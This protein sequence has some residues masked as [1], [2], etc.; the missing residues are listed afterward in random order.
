MGWR[1]QPVIRVA[2]IGDEI[3]VCVS[4][5]EIYLDDDDALVN[6][7]EEPAIAPVGNDVEDLCREISH[8]WISALC[9]KPVPFEVLKV[10]MTFERTVEQSVR[11]E[12]ADYIDRG[13]NLLLS[14]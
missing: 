7:T 4:L 12:L 9:W 2:K 5:V 14:Q 6:W 10:G 3:D 8:M 13:G 11:N 1:Y